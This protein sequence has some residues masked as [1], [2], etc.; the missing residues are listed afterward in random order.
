MHVGHEQGHVA[1]QA[2]SHDSDDPVLD[3]AEVLVKRLDEPDDVVL[4]ELEYV[5]LMVVIVGHFAS[6]RAHVSDYVADIEGGS[7]RAVGKI[8]GDNCVLLVGYE[9]PLDDEPA[10]HVNGFL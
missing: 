5:T 4:L 2:A 8:E 10:G 1:A 9:F 3:V 6:S 7:V